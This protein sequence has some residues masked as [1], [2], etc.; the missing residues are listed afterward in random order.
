MFHVKQHGAKTQK[1][2]DT[3]FHVKHWCVGGTTFSC[4]TRAVALDPFHV[5][6]FVKVN[7]IFLLTYT[8]IPED[9]IQ[10]VFDIDPAQQP[11][12]GSS[13]DPQFFRG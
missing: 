1:H 3:M 12:E 2:E 8:K 7:K 4:E 13:R 10:Q 9:H 5:K 11:T 6:R